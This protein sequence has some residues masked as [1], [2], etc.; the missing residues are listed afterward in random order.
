MLSIQPKK[1]TH[2]QNWTLCFTL[3][4][5]QLEGVIATD[6]NV[7]YLWDKSIKE[8]YTVIGLKD[9]LCFYDIQQI[10]QKVEHGRYKQ[11]QLNEKTTL[12]D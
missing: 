4:G 2:R 12:K 1:G 11:K 10:A 5:D 8:V 7:C 9:C 6:Y 3:K